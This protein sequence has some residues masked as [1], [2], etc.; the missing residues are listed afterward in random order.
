MKRLVN[1]SKTQIEAAPMDKPSWNPSPSL[2]A[3]TLFENLCV[4]S[5][6]AGLREKGYDVKQY[7]KTVRIF[8][9]QDSPLK[10]KNYTDV[11]VSFSGNRVVKTK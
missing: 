2:G 5:L 9:P 7:G 3:N 8:Q 1:L 4:R 11:T 6:L 10:G